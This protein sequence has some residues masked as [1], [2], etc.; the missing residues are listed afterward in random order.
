MMLLLLFNQHQ[1][2][3]FKELKELMNADENDLKAQLIPL[4]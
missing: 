1:M 3:N 4:C 2:V